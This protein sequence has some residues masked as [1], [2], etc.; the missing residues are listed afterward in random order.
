MYVNKE[1]PKKIP[2]EN[3]ACARFDFIILF[4]I[5]PTIPA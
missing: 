3:I 4:F 1:I 2:R 5:L